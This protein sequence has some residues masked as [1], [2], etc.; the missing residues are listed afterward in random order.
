M[1]FIGKAALVSAVGALFLGASLAI[2]SATP[3]SGITVSSGA[4]VRATR[5]QPDK[6]KYKPS[7]SSTSA[8]TLGDNSSSGPGVEGYSVDGIGNVS[9]NNN[10]A[11]YTLFSYSYDNSAYPFAAFNYDGYGME[12]DSVG[13]GYFSG[14]VTATGFNTDLKTRGGG[15][16]GGFSATSTRPVLEDTG[17]GRLE[18]GMA[19]V[20]FDP[21]LSDAIEATR[22][23]QVFLTPDGDTRGLF[24]SQKFQGGFIVRE[25]EHGRGNLYFD[26]RVVAHPAG[27]P[28]V[29]LPELARHRTPGPDGRVV[30]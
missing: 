15:A 22:G 12:L 2:S 11:Y 28:L 29:R 5:V 1:K 30:H 3:G 14:T 13:D 8:C 27:A 18:G 16:V 4:P 26:Y 19:A 23:Y 20:R 21:Q 7:C 25:V 24:V 17:T 9:Y 6:T 10:S